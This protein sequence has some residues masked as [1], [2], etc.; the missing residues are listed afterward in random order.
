MT[1]DT[2]KKI[3]VTAVVLIALLGWRLHEPAGN[4]LN[5]CP[6]DISA[7]RR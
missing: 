1:D 5:N 3:I 4:C 2:L 6:T 7:Q